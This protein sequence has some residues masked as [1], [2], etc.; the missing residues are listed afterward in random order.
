MFDMTTYDITALN[1]I[2]ISGVAVDDDVLNSG[3]LSV[4]FDI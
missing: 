2:V 1:A 3:M 4:S